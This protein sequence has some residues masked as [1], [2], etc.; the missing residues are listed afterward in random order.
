MDDQSLTTPK[1]PLF[2][3]HLQEE[4]GSQSPDDPCIIEGTKGDDHSFGPLI[5]LTKQNLKFRLPSAAFDVLPS[6]E[7]G[8][9][10][11]TLQAPSLAER[12]Y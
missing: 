10:G 11:Q 7:L 8:V 9:L 3:A 1:N 6:E 12:R 5:R 4:E 2:A